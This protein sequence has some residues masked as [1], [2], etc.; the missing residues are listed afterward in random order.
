MTPEKL[1]NDAMAAKDQGSVV[2]VSLA[3]PIGQKR[4]KGF[5]RGELLSETSRGKVYSFDPDKI[6]SWLAKN[7]LIDNPTQQRIDE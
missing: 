3:F 6:L 7:N 4:P 1:F 2:G 5:P